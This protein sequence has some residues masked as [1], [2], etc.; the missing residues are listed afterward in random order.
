MG[1]LPP[2]EDMEAY[3]GFFPALLQ[4]WIG[5]CFRPIEFF[6]S[7][8]NSQDLSPALLFGVLV[9]WVSVIVSS[10]WSLMFQAPLLPMMRQ[11]EMAVQLFGTVGSL[12]CVGLFG[13]LFVLLGIFING[14]IIHLF[15]MLFGGANQ[16]LTMTLR[17][18][19]Y[20][21]APQIFGAIIPIIGWCIISIWQPVLD[22]IGLAAAHRTDTWRAALAV[23]VPIALGVWVCC[24]LWGAVIGAILADI[25]QMLAGMQ[26]KPIP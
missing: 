10:L 3:G 17:V 16:G 19:S 18:I 8:G 4:T 14:L 6:E 20:A 2:F 23:I 7:V 9:G 13:W 25:Q 12:L 1:N 24:L 11:E 22:I 26:Q 15:L 5:A 21:Y